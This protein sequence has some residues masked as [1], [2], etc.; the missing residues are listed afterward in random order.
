MTFSFIERAAAL[1]FADETDVVPLANPLSEK[2]TV[3]RPT[4]LAGLVESVVHNRNRGRRDV[5]LFE[6]GSRFRRSAGETRSVAFVWTGESSPEHWS[7][8]RRGIDFFDIKGVVER[9]CSGFGLVA[10][11]RTARVRHFVPGRSAA[12]FVDGR[13][14]GAVG[15]ILPQIPAAGGLAAGDEIYG[16]ELELD[17]LV[18][19]MRQQRTIRVAPLPRFPTVVR[20][21]S[22]VIDEALPATE[23]R[24]TI[25]SAAPET[26]VSVAEFD[27]Y[28]GPGVPEGRVSLSFRLTFRSPERTLTDDEVQ[29]AV[30]TVVKALEQIHGA[31]QR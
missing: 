4:L 25:R 18:E 6:V 20:D 8:G 19:S 12:V 27:R 9:L 15:Q 14:V 17:V 10:E 5:A 3:L 2:F 13:D 16:C 1:P 23:V 30:D 11:C 24:G 31:I 22:I 28:T 29:R 26:L 21:L 7:G